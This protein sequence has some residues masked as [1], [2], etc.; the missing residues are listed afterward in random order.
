MRRVIDHGITFWK[1]APD[2]ANGVFPGLDARFK[3]MG[4]PGKEYVLGTDTERSG[5]VAML[6]PGRWR[7]TRHNLL[8]R[9]SSVIA[10]EDCI[11][12][13]IS[14]TLIDGASEAIQLLFYKNFATTLVHRLS[15][16]PP[17]PESR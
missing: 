6:P 17:V 8:A 1:L 7:V 10:H 11:L 16:K 9:D 2:E 13:K 14:A 15:N 5:L 4:W 12:M 3:V